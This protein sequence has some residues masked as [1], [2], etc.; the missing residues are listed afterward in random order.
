MK[1]LAATVLAVSILGAAPAFADGANPIENAV[2]DHQ[3]MTTGRYELPG[4]RSYR[5][6]TYRYARPTYVEP[7]YGYEY[8]RPAYPYG[9]S[10]VYEDDYPAY[11][12]EY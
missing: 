7:M 11:G 5:A 8:A 4:A 2:K 10:V 1:I 12:S 9:G 6:Y 3:M